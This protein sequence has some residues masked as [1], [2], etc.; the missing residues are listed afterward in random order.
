MMSQKLNEY[1]V[2]ALIGIG[3]FILGYL[4]IFYI[5]RVIYV[6]PRISPFAFSLAAVFLGICPV[7]IYLRRSIESTVIGALISVLYTISLLVGLELRSM[8]MKPWL[9]YV[10][11]GTYWEMLLLTTLHVH[12]LDIIFY[13]LWSVVLGISILIFTDIQK[14]NVLLMICLFF[15]MLI[16]SMGVPNALEFGGTEHEVIR[17]GIFGLCFSPLVKHF[18]YPY[19]W[20]LFRWREQSR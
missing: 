5:F 13:G 8:L 14:R 17:R 16:V 19:S 9:E 3:S 1:I 18:F 4:A 10:G 15:L 12:I 7:M 6:P 11:I 2:V 20:S